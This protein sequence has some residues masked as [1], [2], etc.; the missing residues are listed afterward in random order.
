M[1]KFMLL[2]LINLMVRSVRSSRLRVR[3]SDFF[4]V[5]VNVSYLF[6]GVFV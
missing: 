4:G 2:Q 6:S 5:D 1:T 3:V